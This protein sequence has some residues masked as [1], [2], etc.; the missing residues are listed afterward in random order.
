MNKYYILEKSAIFIAKINSAQSV[1]GQA[2][3][4]NS[5]LFVLTAAAMPNIE[6]PRVVMEMLLMHFTSDCSTVRLAYPRNKKKQSNKR[7]SD[8]YLKANL[9][10]L[11]YRLI[12]SMY[13]FVVKQ[14]SILSRTMFYLK[15]N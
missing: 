6:V 5:T 2:N 4:P 7:S 13:Q 11:K 1:L 14:I 10:Y 12:C 9:I 8:D 3:R 15:K